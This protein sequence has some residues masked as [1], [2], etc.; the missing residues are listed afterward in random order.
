M[1]KDIADIAA[2]GYHNDHKYSMIQNQAAGGINFN[3][4]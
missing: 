4:N 1:Y 2:C 3:N